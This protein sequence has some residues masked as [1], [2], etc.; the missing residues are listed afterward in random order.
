MLR[1]R[2]LLC[3]C[4]RERMH[5]IS[6]EFVFSFSSRVFAIF[7]PGLGLDQF[8]ASHRIHGMIFRL[9]WH[10]AASSTL[11]CLSVCLWAETLRMR[12]RCAGALAHTDKLDTQT[13]TRAHLHNGWVDGWMDG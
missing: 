3:D 2:A 1:I 10:Q 8:I 11:P 7:I 5:V 4:S 12:L 13:H 6:G 9:R